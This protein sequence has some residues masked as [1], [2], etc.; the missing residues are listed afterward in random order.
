MGYWGGRTLND[1]T[2]TYYDTLHARGRYC[3][4]NSGLGKTSV[5]GRPGLE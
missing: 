5:R 3:D 1:V 4:T 2:Y